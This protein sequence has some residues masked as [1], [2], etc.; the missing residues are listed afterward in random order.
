MAVRQIEIFSTGCP[1]CKEIIQLIRQLDCSSAQFVIVNV[2][3]KTGAQRARDL[4]LRSFPAIVVDGEPMAFDIIN[5]FWNSLRES[6]FIRQV[7][8]A[9]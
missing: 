3:D 5:A 1:I 2:N 6:D 7:F 4:S 9:S 8:A